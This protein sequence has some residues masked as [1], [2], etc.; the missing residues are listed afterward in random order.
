MRRPLTLENFT[1]LFYG[2]GSQLSVYDGKHW[3]LWHQRANG[4]SD[5]RTN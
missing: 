1:T 3:L 4:I 2:L 5:V